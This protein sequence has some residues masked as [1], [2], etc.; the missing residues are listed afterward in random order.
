MIRYSLRCANGH[1]TESWFQSAEAYD[2]LASA[3]QLA[4]PICGDT[5]VEKAL[6]APSVPA[7]GREAHDPPISAPQA[8]ASTAPSALPET[9]APVLSAPSHPLEAAL[10]AFRARVEA[11]AENVGR[12]FARVA[13]D[14]HH[15][16][17]EARPIYGEATR[18]EAR[19]LIDDGVPVAPLPWTG[20]RDD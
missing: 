6:M 12:D 1:V 4:C 9:P 20:R 8:G 18:E 5:R 7:K 15:G 2:R 3:G 14:I 19:E 13:R 11:S 17:D 10:K 16:D